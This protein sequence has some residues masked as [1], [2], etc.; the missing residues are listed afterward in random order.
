MPPAAQLP[1]AYQQPLAAARM[2]RL[3]AAYAE[4]QQRLRQRHVHQRQQLLAALLPVGEHMQ[5]QHADEGLLLHEQQPAGLPTAL[6][7]P[8]VPTTPSTAAV[9]QPQ[10]RS[11]SLQSAASMAPLLLT[12]PRSTHV[13]MSPTSPLRM[14]A[15]LPPGLHH[16]PCSVY[17]PGGGPQ[18]PTQGSSNLGPLVGEAS[19]LAASTQL[20]RQAQAQQALASPVPAADAC[21]PVARPP[22]ATSLATGSSGGSGGGAACSGGGGAAELSCLL[23]HRTGASLTVKRSWRSCGRGTPSAGLASSPTDRWAAAGRLRRGCLAVARRLRGVPCLSTAALAFSQALQRRWGVAASSLTQPDTVWGAR[24]HPS[25]HPPVTA[26]GGGERW[27]CGHHHSPFCT[28]VHPPPPPAPPRLSGPHCS[29][30]RSIAPGSGL[31][32]GSWQA[33]SARRVRASARR[34]WM[35]RKWRKG[36]CAWVSPVPPHLAPNRASKP[37][38]ARTA[39]GAAGQRLCVTA[40]PQLGTVLASCTPYYSFTLFQFSRP[41]QRPLLFHADIFNQS[42]YHLTTRPP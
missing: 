27:A 7:Q 33:G 32:Q 26:W 3:A 8:A 21:P 25:T 28:A 38:A 39:A 20:R 18:L 1:M 4:A 9:P 37:R 5:V 42:R 41:P 13:V 15:P 14:S 31:L 29:P 11:T 35:L 30:W 6:V 2:H 23:P 10:P 24:C 36:C 22:S 40:A 19:P 17:S 12:A 34:P 16:Q